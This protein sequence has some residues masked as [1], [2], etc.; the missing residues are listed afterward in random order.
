M[1][2]EMEHMLNKKIA[3][4]EKEN[5]GLK[6][7]LGLEKEW[8]QNDGN[9]IEQFSKVLEKRNDELQALKNRYRWRDVEKE[10]PEVFGRKYE[11][12]VEDVAGQR[13]IGFFFEDGAWE[14]IGDDYVKPMRWMPL[15]ELEKGDDDV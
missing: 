14:V 12:V 11:N 7:L 13:W 5:K 10:L 2:V 9:V 4:L 1:S 6:R 8:S 3:K 15:P